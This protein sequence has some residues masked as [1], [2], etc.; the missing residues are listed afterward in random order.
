MLFSAHNGSL[1]RQQPRAFNRDAAD[2]EGGRCLVYG[3]LLPTP[4]PPTRPRYSVMYLVIANRQAT[5][6]G[7]CAEVACV[8]ESTLKQEMH[9]LMLQSEE[10]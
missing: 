8:Q 1:L 7:S 6:G 9:A 10:D 2:F 5:L 4:H 3:D